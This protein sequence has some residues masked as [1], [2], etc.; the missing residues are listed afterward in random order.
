MIDGIQ[1]RV[2]A[3]V[4]CRNAHNKEEIIKHARKYRD[5]YNAEGIS[6]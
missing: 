3:Q 4:S 2:L 1:G 5:A 6:K